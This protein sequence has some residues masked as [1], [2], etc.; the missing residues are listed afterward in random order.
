MNGL[1][2]PRPLADSPY[3]VSPIVR[4][5]DKR[6]RLRA[7]CSRLRSK[8]KKE[9][10]PFERR[11]LERGL[12]EVEPSSIS[13]E[14]LSVPMKQCDIRVTVELVRLC[15]TP[16]FVQQ[17]HLVVPARRIIFFTLVT[18]RYIQ[19]FDWDNAREIRDRRT[20]FLV[21]RGQ[22]VS[23]RPAPRLLRDWVEVEKGMPHSR[24][25]MDE[26]QPPKKAE[27]LRPKGIHYVPSSK[28][29]QAPARRPEAAPP[30]KAL[31]RIRYRTGKRDKR[32]VP[33]TEDDL[34]VGQARPPVRNPL[35]GHKC[36]I[37]GGV[38]S[39]PVVKA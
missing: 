18:D 38:K 36:R 6:G 28:I 25:E 4:V 34:Y 33:L 3:I 17:P 15:P 13:W 9:P 30:S 20:Y 8:L 29:R 21:L 35:N 12:N 31:T 14:Y 37:C 23:P 1:L 19:R 7:E 2:T 10:N 39:N 22:L 16:H 32:D 26:S 5:G 24:N 11:V 27:R